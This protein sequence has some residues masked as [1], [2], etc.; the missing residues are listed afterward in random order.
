MNGK[1]GAGLVL[2]GPL[3]MDT[4][5][6]VLKQTNGAVGKADL[7]MDFAQTT[8]IDSSALALMMQWRRVAEAAGRTVTFANVPD[9]L[10]VLAELYGVSFLLDHHPVPA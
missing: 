6:E 3:V 10:R 5:H 9:N 1:E 4:V 2:T 8:D 7:V